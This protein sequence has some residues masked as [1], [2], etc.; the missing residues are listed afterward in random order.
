MKCSRHV[1]KVEIKWPSQKGEPDCKSH[2]TT[3]WTRVV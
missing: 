2:L 3:D 1:S